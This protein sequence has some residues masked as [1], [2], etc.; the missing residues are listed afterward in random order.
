[1]EDLEFD[2]RIILE[3]CNKKFDVGLNRIDVA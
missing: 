2:W 1:M 3:Y